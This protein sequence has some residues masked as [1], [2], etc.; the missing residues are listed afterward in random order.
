MHV[1]Q[2]PR[3]QDRHFSGHDTHFP[4]NSSNPFEQDVQVRISVAEQLEHETI[5]LLQT[6]SAS[7]NPILQARQ[8]VPLVQEIQLRWH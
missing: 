3:L 6:P 4:S 2:I 1:A 5:Q 7:A 8:V